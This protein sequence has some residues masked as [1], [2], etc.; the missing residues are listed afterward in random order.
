MSGNCQ[1]ADYSNEGEFNTPTRNA[2]LAP[3]AADMFDLLCTWFEAWQCYELNERPHLPCPRVD[4]V[5]PKT[6]DLLRELKLKLG[7]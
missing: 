3:Y 1:E 7:E 2:I 6:D 5:V 4:E